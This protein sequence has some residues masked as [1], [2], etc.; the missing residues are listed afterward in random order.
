ML[1]GR[2][3]DQI[4]QLLHLALSPLLNFDVAATQNGTQRNQITRKL[5]IS[6]FAKWTLCFCHPCGLAMGKFNQGG[7]KHYEIKTH[8]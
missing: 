2:T 6:K 3:R 5:A 4:S 1:Y 8:I 7:N